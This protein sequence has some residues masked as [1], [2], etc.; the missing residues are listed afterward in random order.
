MAGPLFEIRDYGEG[1][2][3]GENGVTYTWHINLGRLFVGNTGSFNK[4]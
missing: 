2:L 3:C 1:S 4:L